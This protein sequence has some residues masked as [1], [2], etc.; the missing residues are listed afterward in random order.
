MKSLTK[1]Q[2]KAV[3]V[4]EDGQIVWKTRTADFYRQQ[5]ARAYDPENAA[6]KWNGR[7]AGKPPKWQFSKTLGDYACT[8][9]LTLVTLRQV[10][11]ALGVPHAALEDSVAHTVKSKK[12]ER[13]KEAVRATV[14]L[15]ADKP[16]WKVRTT[17]NFPSVAAAK[18]V[19]FNTRYAG[20][21][22][23]PRSDGLYRVRFHAVSLEQMKEWLN[24]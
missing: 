21:P 6:I 24:D 19:D 17:V 7:L 2:I 13:A 11:D 12:L 14:E 4:I 8:A 9:C 5:F 10:V 22:L 16:H 18:L 1:E 23:S 3:F 15:I 20:K